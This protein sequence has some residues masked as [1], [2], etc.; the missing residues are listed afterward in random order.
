M[1]GFIKLYREIL[2]WQWYGEAATL[3]LFLHLLL[4]VNYEDKL[5]QGKQVRR[6]Q[7]VASTEKLSSECG[8]TKSQIRTALRHLQ[9]SGDIARSATSRYCVITVNRY[10]QYQSATRETP[11]ARLPE[12]TQNAR[13]TA[14]TKEEKKEKK[15]SALLFEQFWEAYPKKAARGRAEQEFMKLQPEEAMVRQM[16]DA[17][18]CQ[19]ADRTGRQYI[20]YPAVWLRERRWEALTREAGYDGYPVLT[21][22]G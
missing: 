5:W 22:E 14:T 3:K 6:G 10:E 13:R 1:I 21:A 9:M 18:E 12:R 17:L 15:Y 11:A 16:L 4:T 19:R 20:P 2:D 8:L 7:R